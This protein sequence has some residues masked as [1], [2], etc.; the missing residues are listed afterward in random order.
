LD[1]TG[2]SRVVLQDWSAGK[3]PWFTI[4]PAPHSVF[5]IVNPELVDM[6]KEE[7]ILSTLATQK[8]MR[9]SKGL[10]RFTPGKID[11]RK[12]VLEESWVA[13][14]QDGSGSESEDRNE[15]GGDDLDSGHDGDSVSDGNLER[16]ED[17]KES[18]PPA[19]R[20]DKRKR[21]LDTLS[22]PHPTK[23]VTFVIDASSSKRSDRAGV[24][25]QQKAQRQPLSK[26]KGVEGKNRSKGTHLPK[27]EKV[28]NVTSISTHQKSD[29]N[30]EGGGEAYN[31]GQFFSARR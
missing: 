21:T 14:E 13:S 16:G 3:F 28:A 8:D 9:R 19:S 7:I 11:D 20:K 2:A 30:A 23:K 1:R 22:T 26:A 27:V 5:Q 15:E 6:A 29:S 10:V 4:P 31:F 18:I 25:T 17:I 24:R 12:M